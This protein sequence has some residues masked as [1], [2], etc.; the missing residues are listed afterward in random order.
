MVVGR[1]ALGD[2]RF[3]PALALF[4]SVI[5]SHTD[6]PL[7]PLAR[8]ERGM[9]RAGR[10]ETQ[11]ALEDFDAVV[12]L[13]QSKPRYAN[14]R[15]PALKVLVSAGQLFDQRGELD[16]AIETLG[17]EK[18]LQPKPDDGFFVRLASLFDRR[19]KQYADESAKLDG[20]EKLKALDSQR[21]AL[22]R[23]GAAFIAISRRATLE[24]D[25]TYAESLWKGIDCFDR[26][27]DT[28]AAINA[29]ELFVAERPS[30]PLAPDAL[31]RL[32]R[33]YQLSGLLDKAIETFQ[34]NQFRY[35]NSL[36]ASKSG[37]PLAQAYMA[38]GPE[39]YDRAEQVLRGVI[40]NNPL[41]TP[42]AAEFRQ[43][44]FELGQLLY[45]T[46]R[47]EEAI[48]RLEEFTTRYP[49]DPRKAQVAFVKADAYRKSAIGLADRLAALDA[50]K[51][52]GDPS[53]RQVDRVEL[54]LARRERL[55]KAKQLFDGIVNQFDGEVPTVELE[56]LYLKL[57]HFYRADCLFDLGEF[58]E[59]IKQYDVAAR[60]YQND[61]GALAAY[62]QIVNAYVA[63]NRP[64]EA[65]AANERAK[66]M[67]RRLPPDAFADNTAFNISRQNWEQWL[68]FAGESGLLARQLAAGRK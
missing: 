19:A 48:A 29:L 53:S 28:P 13:V 31:L 26:A 62:V 22:T 16:A 10:G 56:A 1:I 8:M 14:L 32:G 51:L 6:S 24:D 30:D 55:R 45:R 67:L 52:T 3:D 41:L 38:K 5:V 66:W 18:T 59:A 36:A 33:T 12:K 65:R 44:V 35:P 58:D 63:L 27:G 47:F 11:A 60:R 39:S 20:A 42:D 37:V 61:P 40:D 23:A 15:E 57:A 68:G 50:G 34:R 17:N 46:G 9:V 43:A 21:E 2:R 4:Q 64:E 7:A 54:V 25:Q 49:D